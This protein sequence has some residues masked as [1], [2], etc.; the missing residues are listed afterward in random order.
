MPDL[1]N[2]SVYSSTDQYVSARVMDQA[3]DNIIDNYQKQSIKSTHRN[4]IYRTQPQ[5][6]DQN[7]YKQ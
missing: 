1:F 5:R 4:R 7:E 2:D 6:K 3:V